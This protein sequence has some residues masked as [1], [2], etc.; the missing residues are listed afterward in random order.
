MKDIRELL[1]YMLGVYESRPVWLSESVDEETHLT[2]WRQI[3]DRIAFCFLS[4]A[5]MATRAP[6]ITP[7]SPPRNLLDGRKSFYVD[8]IPSIAVGTT[9]RA[10]TRRR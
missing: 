10:A 3:I 6:L 1:D 9:L 7:S 8:D 5:T 4:L 2:T